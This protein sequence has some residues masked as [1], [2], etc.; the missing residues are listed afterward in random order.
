MSKKARLSVFAKTPG[1]RIGQ[2]KHDIYLLHLERESLHLVESPS[3][4]SS[5]PSLSFLSAALQHRPLECFD[6]NPSCL[7]VF[8]LPILLAAQGA[9]GPSHDL[10][11]QLESSSSIV[12]L[13]LSGTLLRFALALKGYEV[14]SPTRPRE[15]DDRPAYPADTGLYRNGRAWC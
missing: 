13:L 6:R 5:I 1:N 8:S 4:S 12:D 7:S 11:D 3:Q 15:D 2:K 10:R 14:V 9:K